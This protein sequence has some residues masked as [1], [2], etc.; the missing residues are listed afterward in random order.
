MTYLE[1]TIDHGNKHKAIM[2]KLIDKS[3]DEVIAYFN[4]ENM[5]K[6]EKDF[7]PLYAEHKK[8]HDIENLNCYICACPHFRFKDEVGFKKVNGK[9]L[10]SYCSI[11]SKKGK[12][13]ESEDSIHQDCSDCVVPHKKMFIKKVFDRDWTKMIKESDV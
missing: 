6:E 5:I 12:T 11:D 8:C 2:Q 13:F 7:C 9:T 3:D 10:F 1:W 4:Y